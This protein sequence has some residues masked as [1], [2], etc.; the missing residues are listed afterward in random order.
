MVM[1]NFLIIGFEKAGTTSVYHYL[2]QH[3]Q[4]FVSPTKETNF[5]IHEAQNPDI[6]PYLPNGLPIIKSLNAYRALF[7][8]ASGHKAVGEA[9]PLYLTDPRAAKRIRHYIPEARLIAILRD[10]AERAYSAYWM[11]VRDGR[12]TRSFEQAIEQ[13]LEGRLDD[14]LDVERR[15]YVRWGLYAQHLKAYLCSFDR[16]QLAI[17]LFDDLQADPEGFMRGLF[18]FLEVD[19]GFIPD[20]SVRYNASGLPRS[21]F[22]RPLFGKSVVTRSLKRALPA[23]LGR[24]AAAFQEAWRSR[25]VAKPPLPSKLRRKL[26][27]GYRSDILELQRIIGRDLSPWLQ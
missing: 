21:R 4:V 13:E 19:D 10:P 11:R 14:S 15:H 16:S 1:P 26:V 12:E 25:A 18:R 22:L 17:Y 3:P 2:K 7:Q 24:R 6:V 27:A 23:P 20:T 5:F 8:D 9:S